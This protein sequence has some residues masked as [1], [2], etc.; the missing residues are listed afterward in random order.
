MKSNNFNSSIKL[1]GIMVG[2]RKEETFIRKNVIERLGQ[3][4]QNIK[5]IIMW[6]TYADKAFEVANISDPQLRPFN[7]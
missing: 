1:C 7:R 6:H 4:H 5:I 2:A 3:T